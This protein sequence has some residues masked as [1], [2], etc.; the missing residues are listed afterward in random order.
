MTKYTLLA[1]LAF[2]LG[3][4]GLVALV[5]EQIR[6]NTL[7]IMAFLT[8]VV[9]PVAAVAAGLFWLL[10]RRPQAQPRQ[11]EEPAVDAAW[12]ELQPGDY[13]QLN[14]PLTM[15]RVKRVNAPL[16]F[17]NGQPAAQ[18]QAQPQPEP[19]LTVLTT[20]VEDANGERQEVECP[21]PLLRVAAQLL[22]EGKQPTR[23]NFNDKGVMASP[24]IR[25]CVNYLRA[26]SWI[27]P[28]ASKNSPARWVEGANP[29]QLKEFVESFDAGA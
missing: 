12:R 6:D 20:A 27:K 2:V 5:V 21:L 8:L 23:E 11:R 15:R 3:V 4:L 9:L 7:A 10:A 13:P 22:E 16:V 24:E 17:M 26:R 18:A 28:A 14:A 25:M 29:Q 1:L 19:E